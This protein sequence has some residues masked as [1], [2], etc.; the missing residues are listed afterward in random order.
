MRLHVDW[1]IDEALLLAGCSMSIWMAMKL[2]EISVRKTLL[3]Q[4]TSTAF[5]FSVAPP[6]YSCLLPITAR[7]PRL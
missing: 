5:S 4:V 1:S 6:A 3:T 2:R 7:L